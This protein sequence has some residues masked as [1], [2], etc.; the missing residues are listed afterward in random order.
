MPEQLDF[1]VGTLTS[2]L[3]GVAMAPFVGSF[4]GVVIHRLPAGEPLVFAHSHCPQCDVR[5]GA[6]DLVPLVSWVLSRGRCRHCGSEI[7]SFY[8]LIE[9]AALGVAVWAFA[10]D[11]GW[12]FWPSCLLGWTL[13]V[14]AV[15]D[16]R[17]FVLPDILTLPLIPVGLALAALAAPGQLIDHVIGTLVGFAVFVLIAAAYRHLRGHEGL[18]M[19]D[20]KLAAAAGAWVTWD[21]LASV[22]LI[23]CVAA[24]AVTAGRSRPGRLPSATE[25]LPFGAYL[26]VGFWLVWLYG[27]IE[28]P[29]G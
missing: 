7:S 15:I 2:P 11:T 16:W 8:P 10:W 9:L 24:L 12:L 14:L 6:R 19:G 21:G 29:T 25:R 26:C 17:H 3:I 13:I 27:P 22:V 28:M 4:L 23:A 18:G 1:L 20:A 5:L